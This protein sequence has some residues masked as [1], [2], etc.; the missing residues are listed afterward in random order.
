MRR[1]LLI[2]CLAAAAAVLG[3]P[4]TALAV[5]TTVS[6]SSS[7]L[8][9]NDGANNSTLQ[10]EPLSSTETRIY[11]WYGTETLST[12]SSSCRSLST[13]RSRA[14]PARSARS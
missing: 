10:I 2:A 3:L 9:V 4:A 14:G 6:L 11:S 13:T 12:S 8:T 7:V 5:T 1:R